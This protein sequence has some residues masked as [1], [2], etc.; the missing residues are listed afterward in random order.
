MQAA[1]A[2]SGVAR[3]VGGAA[4]DEHRA[5]A[6]G[7]R[8]E[9]PR[10]AVLEDEAVGGR[11]AERA[12]ALQVSVRV[13]FRRAHVVAA[14]ARARIDAVRDAE[15]AEEGVDHGARARGDDAERE[16]HRG[17]TDRLGRARHGRDVGGD[18]DPVHEQLFGERGRAARHAGAGAHHVR[19]VLPG[20]AAG[21]RV[22][23]GE[24][25]DAVALGDHADRRV[26]V[27][28]AV[29]QRAVE[30]EERGPHGG[31]HSYVRP[32]CFSQPG[33]CWP[34]GS[35]WVQC[36]TPPLSFHS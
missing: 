23:Q 15:L 29:D 13:G 9:Q 3:D 33:S 17:L 25:G 11:D 35:W 28:L 12:G 20:A 2:S 16:P 27:D 5:H 22:R 36:T 34:C 8:G 4:H 10:L 26:R 7:P 24:V 1:V 21:L 6:G 18:A 32:R 19:D 30:V 31:R 14:D